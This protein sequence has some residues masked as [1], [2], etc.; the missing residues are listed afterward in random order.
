MIFMLATNICICL[1]NRRTGYENILARIDGIAYKQVV[2]SSVTL[3]ELKHCITKS[4]KKKANRIKLG[5]FLY[6]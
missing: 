6:H 2:I 1:S 4:V 5:Y 3:A